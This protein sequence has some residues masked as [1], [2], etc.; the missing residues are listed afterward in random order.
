MKTQAH[1][2]QGALKLFPLVLTI[3]FVVSGGAYGLEEVMQSG[4]GMGLLLILLVPIFWSIPAALMT[5]ELSSAMPKEGGF[6][7]WV[8]RAM[9]PYWGFLCAWWTWLY[10]WVDVSIYPVLFT[11]YFKALIHS[12]VL[13]NP[14]VDFLVSMS[15]IVPLTY[16]N[17][18]GTKQVGSTSIL[19]G[20]ILLVP[21]IIL[22]FMGIGN[23]FTNF[24]LAYSPFIPKD[25]TYWGAFASGLYVVMWNYLGWDSISTISEEVENPRRNLV[26]AFMWTMPLIIL[27]YFLPTLIGIT[28]V[29]D[30][31]Q[32]TEGSWPMIAE[33]VGGVWLGKAIAI[34][35]LLSAAGLFMAALLASSRLPFVLAEDKLMFPI[36]T[37][38]HPKFGTPWVAILMSALVYSALTL[39][40]T[41]RDLAEIDVILY[42]AGL[43]LEFVALLILRIKEPNMERPFKIGGGWVGLGLVV[44]LP[45]LI[46]SFAIYSLITDPT[47]GWLTLGLSAIAL[48]SGVVL[49]PILR[50]INKGK[51]NLVT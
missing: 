46:V 19:F 18:R 24:N 3:F 35:G 17:I 25:S 15:M 51:S 27:A 37:K 34:C 32:W 20:L 47:Q 5:S 31:S 28:Y 48:L 50:I 9:G 39:L 30:V 38:I 1:L 36:A 8:K 21:F 45:F 44:L 2:K 16:I 26:K 41:F 49:Y 23:V 12:P 42:S 4:A 43:L 14:W 6:Y 11:A 22:I 40:M 7:V 10:S 33:K 29:S 13:E